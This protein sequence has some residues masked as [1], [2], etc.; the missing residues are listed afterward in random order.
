MTKFADFLL[1]QPLSLAGRAADL[2][3]ALFINSVTAEQTLA[4]AEKPKVLTEDQ[5]V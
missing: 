3:Q 1:C 4:I 5:A 2:I